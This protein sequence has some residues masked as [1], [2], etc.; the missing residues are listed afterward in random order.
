MKTDEKGNN[1]IYITPFDLSVI[2]VVET[3]AAKT[4]IYKKIILKDLGI[5]HTAWPKMLKNTRNVSTKPTKQAEMISTLKGKYDVDPDYIRRYP[6]HKNMFL[7]PT[8]AADDGDLF[9]AQK[10]G[11]L[12]TLRKSI[13]ACEGMIRDLQ[14]RDDEQKAEILRLKQALDNANLLL[15]TYQ[16]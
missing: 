10:N 7:T 8:I 16:K 12:I 2:E 3:I 4:G 5:N 9:T 15:A 1:V 11:S 14:H 6:S 13:V